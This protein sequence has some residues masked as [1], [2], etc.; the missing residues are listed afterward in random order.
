MIK[1]IAASLAGAAVLAALTACGTP[2]SS[3]SSSPPL[4]QP[5]SQVTL[6]CGSVLPD[7]STPASIISTLATDNAPISGDWVT[8]EAEATGDVNGQA[9][10][11]AAQ[12]KAI[13]DLTNAL[14]DLDTASSAKGPLAAAVTTLDNS[15]N[16]LTNGTPG[17]Q[18]AGAVVSAG[19]SALISACDGAAS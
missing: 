12:D 2:A 6:T 4:W 3:T 17:W 13:N 8:A 18:S 15:A 16:H 1:P 10:P 5:A 19:I 9:S 14:R 7:G 11:S